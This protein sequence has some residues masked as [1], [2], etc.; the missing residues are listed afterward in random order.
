MKNFLYLAIVF[1]VFTAAKQ[2]QKTATVSAPAAR[3]ASSSVS[4]PN[5]ATNPNN[6]AA[7]V[8]GIASATPE[9]MTV[10]SNP[11]FMDAIS[12]PAFIDVMS[13]PAL[14]DLLTNPGMVDM[15]SGKP[16]EVKA[17]L[18][19]MQTMATAGPAIAE[20]APAM[21][22]MQQQNQAAAAAPKKR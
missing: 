10:L 17:R 7:A 21:A 19:A 5:K 11:A 13:N 20:I 2:D 8:A 18:D 1:L 16:E 15:L 12:N 22:A 9:M 3:A 4:A 6:T 14:L